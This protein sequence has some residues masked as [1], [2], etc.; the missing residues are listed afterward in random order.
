MQGNKIAAHSVQH[1]T[2][3]LLRAPLF[4]LSVVAA[5]AV[6]EKGYEV[7][8]AL[9]GP[10]STVP[11]AQDAA[12][13]DTLLTAAPSFA[14]NSEAEKAA[15]VAALRREGGMILPKILNLVEEE[16]FAVYFRTFVAS[17]DP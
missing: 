3:R 17:F 7:A 10:Q 1:F 14:P 12:S 16:P 9:E 5:S 13:E 4:L 11:P 6:S 15:T 8:L 2:A